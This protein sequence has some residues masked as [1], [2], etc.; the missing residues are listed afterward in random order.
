MRIL[1]GVV[2]VGMGHASRSEVVIRHLLAQGHEV[3]VV[4]YGQ[5]LT[6]LDQR[7]GGQLGFSARQIEGLGVCYDQRGVLDVPRS[8]VSLVG[9]APR[10][11]V[12]NLG[13]WLSQMTDFPADAVISDFD[14]WSW[15]WAQVHGVPVVALDNLQLLARCE[16]PRELVA[17]LPNFA[18]SRAAIRA[19]LPGRAYHYVVPT[20][21]EPLAVR[22]KTTLVAPILRPVVQRARRQPGEHVVVYQSVWSAAL[23]AAVR[24]LGCEVRAYGAPFEGQE[25]NV[26]WRAFSEEGFVDDLRTARA[27][28]AGG[29][30]SLMCEAVWLGVPMLSVPLGGHVEQQ[31]NARWLQREGYGRA[32][33]QLDAQVLQD[34]LGELPALERTL[35]RRPLPD[36]AQALRTLEILLD[37]MLSGHETRQPL[38]A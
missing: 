34:F 24:S 37:R 19:K 10:R 12:S 27:V 6:V 11:L 3:R 28:V 13:T 9:Q 18:L 32:A 21:Y 31:L 16:H 26:S 36:P 30:F 5:A 23:L 25:G 2:G 7:L 17:D 4:S 15:S 38:A 14:S 20:F 8:V 35:A 1:Y 22:P 33:A 29:G